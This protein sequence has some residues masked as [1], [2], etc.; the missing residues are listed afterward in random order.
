MRGHESTST[1]AQPLV[2]IGL[3][4]Y[5]GG[6]YLAESVDSLLGQTY[7]RL[8]LVISDNASTDSTRELCEGFAAQDS[9]VRYSRREQNIGGVRNH[10]HV[11]GEAR[12]ELFMWA[13]ADDRW[14]PTYVER[15]VEVLLSDPTVVLAYARNATM[16]EHGTSTG[17]Y[18]A[19]FALDTDDVV[20]RFRQLTQTD[21]PIEPFYGVMRVAALRRTTP[22]ALHPGFDR[23]VLAEL[24]L[25]G[26]FRQV[27][28]PLYVRRIHSDQSVRA[29]PKLRERYLWI[30]PAARN[31]LIVLPMWEFGFRFAAAALRLAPGS[32]ARLRC[33]WHMLKWCNWNR[34]R[35]GADLLGR[36]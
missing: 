14:E 5:N 21:N 13:S 12:G 10:S 35:L 8:E 22:L 4:V 17:V 7:R 2:T 11:V 24:G 1:S 33:L 3:P 28:E 34:R 31:R 16:D 27:D 36:T 18:P 19:G 23:F 26:R 6:K 20:D 15:C 9:R 29:F 25:L 30:N 32:G